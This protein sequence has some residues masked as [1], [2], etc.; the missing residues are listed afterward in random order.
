MFHRKFSRLALALAALIAL[1]LTTT[2]ANAATPVV[3]TEN[4]KVRGAD[5]AGNYAF[6]GL[7][8]AAAPVGDLRWRA[9][10]PAA[11]W[12]GVR[13]ATQYAPSSPQGMGPFTP[14]GPQSEDSLYL[15]VSTPTLRSSAGRPVIVWIHGGGLTIDGARNYDATKLAAEGTVVVTLNYRLGLLG[16]LAHPAL[17]KADGSTGNYGL[18]D[19]QAA[20]RWVQRNISQFGGDPHNVTIAGQSAGGLSVLAHNRVGAGRRAFRPRPAAHR[21]RPRREPDLRQRAGRQR[22]QRPAARAGDGGELPARDRRR[23]GRLAAA[24]RGDRRRVP[25]ERV[26]NPDGGL[27][28]RRL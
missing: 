8:Y 25:A 26:P 5:V 10:R 22:P 18:M 4:G 16:F 15:N 27:Q 17:A 13:D 2:A 28:R 6:R 3:S 11:D 7:P 24:R 21:R 14:E 9:P 12:K 20:L 1:L 19:Q 23:P